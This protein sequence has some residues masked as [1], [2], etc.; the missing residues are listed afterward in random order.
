[1]TDTHY[2]DNLNYG[3]CIG[4][5]SGTQC[6]DQNWSLN[7]SCWT[8]SERHACRQRQQFV[9]KLRHCR[10]KTTSIFD[11]TETTTRTSASPTNV[12]SAT[13]IARAIDDN[14]IS[15]K[16]QAQAIEF[17]QNQTQL[18]TNNKWRGVRQVGVCTNC[19][20]LALFAILTI[21]MPIALIQKYIVEAQ[22][23]ESAYSELD[24]RTLTTATI[25]KTLEYNQV[26]TIRNASRLCA[27]SCEQPTTLMLKFIDSPLNASDNERHSTLI[28]SVRAAAISDA[29]DTTTFNINGSTPGA[30][31]VTRAT[32]NTAT[33][34]RLVASEVDALGYLQRYGY[35]NESSGS[36]NNLISEEAFHEAIMSFQRFAGLRETG[37]L[38]AKTIQYMEMPRCGNKDKSGRGENGKKRKRRK[39]Y[40]LQG[41]K[42]RRT[43]LTYRISQYPT[44]FAGKKHEVDGQIEKAFKIWSQV[45]PIDF[46]VK[47]EGRV[48]IDIKFASGDHGDGDPFDGPGNTLAH[49]YFPQYGGDAHFDDQEY[50]TVDSYA[51]TNI[52]QVAAHELGHSLGLGH[53]SVREALMAPFYQ[54]Y[55]PNFK[56]HA[57]DILGIQAL[58]GEKSED[59]DDSTST[60]TSTTTTTNTTKPSARKPTDT[61]NSNG[62][63]DDDENTSGSGSSGGDNGTD[64]PDLCSDGRID[65]ITRTQDK[66]TF[67]FKG[68]H[69]WLI[70][71]DG[72]ASGYPQRIAKD[73]DGLPSNLDAALT[74]ADGKTFFFKGDKYWRFTN[75][76]REP[77][78]PKLISAGF[79]GIPNNV[80][81][82][83]VWSGNGKTYF[84]KGSQYWRFDSKQEPPVSSQYPKSIKN[85][86]GLPTRGIDAAFKWENGMTY[87]FKDEQYYRFND[88]E[89]EVDTSAKPA[90]P[91]ATGEWWFGCTA[92]NLP[93]RGTPASAND[94][95]GASSSLSSSTASSSSL[96]P[97]H[98][99][100]ESSSSGSSLTSVIDDLINSIS[101]S[102][103]HQQNS[104]F[105]ASRSSDNN[106]WSYHRGIGEES[107][108]LFKNHPLLRRYQES[109][110][111]TSLGRS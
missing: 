44:R 40:A 89:F 59:D 34:A 17:I 20:S 88:L 27:N 110:A 90:F 9:N 21:I 31:M 42:W 38:D 93:Q 14:R 92:S 57:D 86:V 22:Q 82:A 104:R 67:V 105:G 70:E 11:T 45:A 75:R 5:C 19:S 80:D 35:M 71:R 2:I 94:L 111:I 61:D 32:N 29:T 51:G 54:K 97:R 24:S 36:A 16:Q 28:R 8:T 85:W 50:W 10:F 96:L 52:F 101:N 95:M 69:Y 7:D 15:D 18:S 79:A 3:F 23:T 64:G 84:F 33:H 53:S 77:G 37:Q 65:A 56:L 47:K 98:Y 41:S 102:N 25:T 66:S 76:R 72:L 39:R 83:F 4:D 62:S 30:A 58:Y 60:S 6:I 55:K 68:A 109:S 87:F 74:W 49:A 106:E 99:S 63:D 1:M 13:T 46:V 48:H 91:R 103:S 100:Q 26:S 108:R 78:Y 107:R 73:W 43:E 12:P 81:A